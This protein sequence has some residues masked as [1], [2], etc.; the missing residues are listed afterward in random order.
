MRFITVFTNDWALTTLCLCDQSYEGLSIRGGTGTS[1]ASLG[2]A[3][4][5]TPSLELRRWDLR[6]LCVWAGVSE[7]KVIV[8]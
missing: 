5:W 2:I 7:W 1:R 6:A 8:G 4:H 3:R